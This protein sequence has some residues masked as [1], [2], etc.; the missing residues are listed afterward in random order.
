MQIQAATI[1]LI[2]S[3]TSRDIVSH[4]ERL[5]LWPTNFEESACLRAVLCHDMVL[6]DSLKL[7]KLHSSLKLVIFGVV[8][9]IS[10]ICTI[11][12]Y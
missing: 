4:F 5:D 2:S 8:R 9:L 1:Q 3:A 7:L 12:L 6:Y 10:R 11:A